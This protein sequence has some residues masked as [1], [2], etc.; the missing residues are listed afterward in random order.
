MDDFENKLSNVSCSPGILEPESHRRG[1]SK[2]DSQAICSQKQCQKH[3][4]D[5]SAVTPVG[6][7]I[8]PNRERSLA[9][10]LR[11]QPDSWACKPQT[12]FA[13]VASVPTADRT[14]LGVFHLRKVRNY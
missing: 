13:P 11:E 3:P 1:R 14:K 9:N 4:Q 12:R 7:K 5:P 2:L 6:R 10:I 8:S